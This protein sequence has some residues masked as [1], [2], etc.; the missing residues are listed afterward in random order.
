[1]KKLTGILFVSTLFFPAMLAWAYEVDTHEEMSAAAVATSVLKNQTDVLVNLGLKPLTDLQTF[2]SSQGNPRTV[3]Q[4]F[5]EG[6]NF[7]D[8]LGIGRPRNHFYNPLNGAPLSLGILPLGSPSP[9]WA[10]EDRGEITGILGFGKQEFSYRDARQYFY[11]ALT[12]STKSERDKNFGLTFQTLGQVIHH[13]QDMAQPQHVRNDQH[14]ELKTSYELALCV[15]GGGI[16]CATYFSIKNPSLYE[17]YTNRDDVRRGLPFSGYAPV[18]SSTDTA[19]FN[20]PRKF[21]H[22]VDG[23]GLADY[24]NRGFV[25]A[26]TIFDSSFPAVLDT[27]SKQSF[28]IQTLLPGTSLKGMMTFYSSTVTDKYAGSSVVNRRA[29]TSSIFDADIKKYATSDKK[30]VLTLN[31]F[32]F[33]A[34]HALLIPRAVGYSAGL[35]NYFFRGKIDFIEDKNNPGK[36][37]IKNLSAEDMQGTFTLYYDAVDNNRYPVAGDAVDKTWASLAVLKNNQVDNL[38][39]SPPVYPVPKEPGKYMLVFNGDLGEEKATTGVTVGAVVAVVANLKEPDL[40]LLD[41]LLGRIVTISA[42]GDFT[43]PPLPFGSILR[44][45]STISS[46]ISIYNGNVINNTFTYPSGRNNVTLRNKVPFTNNTNS[47]DTASSVAGIFIA[48]VLGVRGDQVNVKVFDHNGNPTNT[49]ASNPIHYGG[50]VRI[51]ANKTHV[52]TTSNEFL[53]IYT[54]DGSNVATINGLNIFSQAV[55][56]TRDRVFYVDGTI[57][58]VFDLTGTVQKTLDLTSVI[59]SPI[60]CFEATEKRFYIVTFSGVSNFLHI[61]TRAVTRDQKGNILSD[62]YAFSKSINLG[63]HIERVGSCSVD[64]AYMGGQ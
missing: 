42:N 49:F 55:T 2:P 10:L 56:M 25:S 12:K 38:G 6:A 39:F 5:R 17:A 57:L 41:W 3:V 29:A 54:T 21:W 37:V 23:K 64:T 53:Y 26:G 22:S 43:S 4:L 19:T 44:D 52:A 31:R 48:D 51:A 60:N 30:E 63:S 47:Y 8:T 58:K 11:D 62:D 27:T 14:L 7:E 1:M 45:G 33:D 61:F 28:D 34:A 46:G 59:N 20:K 40:Q 15:I 24:T 50:E 18:Y 9:D 35:I 32:N 13:V 36:Y 16:S